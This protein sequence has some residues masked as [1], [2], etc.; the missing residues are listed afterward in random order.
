MAKKMSPRRDKR[1]FR[2]T[3]KKTNSINVKV[4]RGG[5]RL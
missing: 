3:A 1:I 5:I 4:A 2:S